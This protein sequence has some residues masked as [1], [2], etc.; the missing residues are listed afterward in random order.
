MSYLYIITAVNNSVRTIRV[1]L[2]DSKEW[3]TFRKDITFVEIGSAEKD[4]L[5]IYFSEKNYIV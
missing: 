3:I 1:G 2:A 5:P 4:L